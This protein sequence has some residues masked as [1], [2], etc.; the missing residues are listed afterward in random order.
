MA[1]VKQRNKSVENEMEEW[2]DV[3]GGDTHAR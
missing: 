1:K 2:M 3:D